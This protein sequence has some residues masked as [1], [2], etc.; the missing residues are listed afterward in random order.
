M[1]TY[2]LI[3]VIHGSVGKPLLTTQAA[4][5]EEAAGKLKGRVEGVSR[6]DNDL[7]FPEMEWGAFV[8]DLTGKVLVEAVIAAVP[9]ASPDDAVR[10][11]IERNFFRTAC[12]RVLLGR[13]LNV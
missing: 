5:I 8:P 3:G 9:E 6:R 13:V 4:T 10:N 1:N 7:F 2:L 11:D 12:E